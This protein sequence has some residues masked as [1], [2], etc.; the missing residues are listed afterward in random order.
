LASEYIEDK[1]KLKGIRTMLLVVAVVNGVIAIIFSLISSF[2]EE[3]VPVY[4]QVFVAGILAY[5]TPIVLYAKLNEV[6]APV[7]AERFYLKGCSKVTML[8]VGLMGI[9]WQFVMGIIN[10]PLNLLVGN[11][12]GY[13]MSSVWELVVAIIV[14]GII[15]AF[16]E[17]FLFRGIVYGSMSEFNTKAAMIFSSVMFA[18]LHADIANFAGYLVMGFVLCDIVRRTESLYATM[19]FHLANNITA[20]LLTFYASEIQYEPVL[21]LVM[22]VCGVLAFVITYILFSR[23]FKTTKSADRIKTSQLLGQ[24]F[25]SIPIILCIAV[26]MVTAFIVSVI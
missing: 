25:I 2:F 10:I 17:E 26:I 3:P 19:M 9:G 20:L 23:L 14:I 15:P 1:H 4:I 7:A 5:I 11:S 24:S 6:T 13:T 21:T 18:L 16:F 22:F 8:L 12:A